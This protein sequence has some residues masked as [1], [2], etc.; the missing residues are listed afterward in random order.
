MLPLGPSSNPGGMTYTIVEYSISNT[1][2]TSLHAMVQGFCQ[3]NNINKSLVSNILDSSVVS[4]VTIVFTLFS[5]NITTLVII[6][7]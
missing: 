5:F 1:R 7:S 3:F 6:Y 2:E 4:Y